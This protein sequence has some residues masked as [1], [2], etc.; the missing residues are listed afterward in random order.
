MPKNK[1]EKLEERLYSRKFEPGKSERFALGKDDAQE[2]KSW[3]DKEGVSDL[4]RTHLDDRDKKGKLLKKILVS[5][6][7]FFAVAVLVSFFIF[8]GGRNAVSSKNIGISVS[9]PSTVAGGEILSLDVTVSNDNNVA[10]RNVVLIV[11]YPNGTKV[12]LDL[13]KELTRAR[14]TIDKIDARARLTKNFKAVLFGEKEEIKQIKFTLEY[15]LE[16]SS[17]LFSKDKFFEILIKSSPVILELNYPNEVNS[18]K[19]FEII[20]SLSSNSLETLKNVLL[21]ATFPFGFSFSDSEPRASDGNNVWKIGDLESGEK[22]LIKIHGS[23]IGEDEDERTFNFS[24]GIEGR[25]QNVIEANFTTSIATIFIKKPFISLSVTIDG[26]NPE[27]FSVIP[28]QKSKVNIVWSNN[29]PETVN[30]MKIE[31]KIEGVVLDRS[32]V[33]TTEGGFYRSFDNTIVWDRGSDPDFDSVSSGEKGVV[34]FSF[35]PIS[36]IS[37]SL[38]NQ[39]IVLNISASGNIS[40]PTGSK[41]VSSSI[42]EDIKIYSALGLSGMA[43]RSIGPFEN[44]GPIPPK[45]DNE[46]TY[47]IIFSLS[48]PFNDIN[49]VEVTGSL[50]SYIAWKNLTSPLNENVTYDE[51]RRVVTWKAGIVRAGLGS[52][53]TRQVAFQ[54]SLTPSL[55]QVGNL[56][57][58]LTD[59]VATGFDQFTNQNQRV[60]ISSITTRTISDP[61]FKEG[62][63]KVVK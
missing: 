22:K 5:S 10:L 17:A 16:G 59:I 36:N 7:I 29:L 14:E 28:G 45:A 30:N 23:I 41:P 51:N 63:D 31:A 61:Q 21:T 13:S 46:T 47:T 1:L 12:A 39:K 55:S 20:L 34:G 54:I 62:D 25:E 2:S 49:S 4:I 57:N 8:F 9:G 37:S 11:E 15:R 42:S 6:I 53:N 27:D 48:S 38:R 32:S 52:G 43:V 50:P 26:K 56:V 40:S 35:A 18:G 24:A 58:L 44:M 19:P 60:T 33:I 3:E